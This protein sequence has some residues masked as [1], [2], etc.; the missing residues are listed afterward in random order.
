MTV[1]G[2]LDAPDAE[3]VRYGYAIG[4]RSG[5]GAAFGCPAVGLD[6]IRRSYT[7]TGPDAPSRVAVG[8]GAPPG[9]GHRGDAGPSSRV[10]VRT[11]R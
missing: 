11:A 8:L 9:V 7:T 3:R 2:T 10:P 6:P 4:V 1:A 5:E